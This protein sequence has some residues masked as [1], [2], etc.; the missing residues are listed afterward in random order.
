MR[1]RQRGFTLLEMVT[2]ILILGAVGLGLSGFTQ[3]AMQVYLDVVTR[4]QLLAQSR[5][6]VER[7]A[8]ELHSA[9]PHSVRITGNTSQHCLQFVPELFSTRYTSVPVQ[10]GAG[11]QADIVFPVDANGNVYPLSRG[12]T[13]L[14]N[15]GAPA[16]VYDS[17]NNHI[18]TVRSCTDDG[19][20]DC[21]TRDDSDDII[22][23]TV[24][25]A[26]AA[27]S[28]TATLYLIS[29]AVSYCVTGNTLV[30]FVSP[31]TAAQPLGTASQPRLTDKV[32]N[33]LSGNPASGSGADDPFV[34]IPPDAARRG[35]VQIRLQMGD[36]EER[37]NWHREVHLENVP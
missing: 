35:A 37:L 19:D 9:V 29:N 16:D 17:S 26:F 1:T 27:D 11:T 34:Y 8:R 22:Q 6:A 32:V 2:V 3:S 5:F 21:A 4:D 20:G 7:M 33:R 12:D 10:P 14:V 30:R 28:P 24:T 25:D 31:I 13:V 36:G 18:Q 23:L 15:P